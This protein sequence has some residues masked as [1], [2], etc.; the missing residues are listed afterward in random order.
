MSSPSPHPSP[1]SPTG[2]DVGSILHSL[3]HSL[4]MTVSSSPWV[5]VVFGLV[6]VSAIVRFVRGVIHSGR[7]N[8]P[9]RLFSGADRRVIFARAGNRCEFVYPVFGRCRA[10]TNLHAD[11]V[12]PHSRGGW[13]SIRNGQALCAQHN[14][15]KSARVPWDWQLARLAKRRA[16]YFVPL[17]DPVVVRH[18]PRGSE[19][20]GK[21]ADPIRAG[22][23]ANSDRLA[24]TGVDASD[25]EEGLW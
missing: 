21:G 16:G 13:T 3:A 2:P 18:R 15:E 25:P 9:V 1:S 20:P 14:R 4:W 11:H 12:H 19:R 10:R 24:A 7:T 5:G 6:L 17:H 8:D 22:R 23:R